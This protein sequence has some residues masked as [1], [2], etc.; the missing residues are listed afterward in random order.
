MSSQLGTPLT[1]EELVELDNFLLSDA[2]DG[3]ALSIDEVHG[4]LT[5]IIVGPEEVDQE[6]WLTAVWGKPRF[7]DEAEEQRMTGRLLRLRNEIAA[8]LEAGRSFEPLVVEVEQDGEVAEAH[9]GWCFGFMLGVAHHQALW[10]RLPRDE[11]TLVEPMAEL[12][13]LNSEEEPGMSEEE[14][15][16]WV[17]L[18][19][20]AVMGLYRFWHGA[21][22]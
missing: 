5:A 17:E 7:A 2:C 13:L 18:V 8:T 11:K 15:T 16:S 12:A 21:Q 1:E 14:Y 3:A 20:G 19:P 4:F 22:G 6:E 9:E 10:D